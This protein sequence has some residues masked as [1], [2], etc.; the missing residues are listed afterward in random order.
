MNRRETDS[1]V[2]MIQPGFL[3]G[4]SRQD[5]IKLARGG[6]VSHWLARRANTLVL[7][8]DGMSCDAVAK[9]LVLDDDTIRAWYRLYQEDGIEGL[10]GFGYDGSACRLSDAQQEKLIAWITET[11][12]RTTR[13]IGAWIEKGCGIEY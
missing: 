6:S 11:L 8:D 10:A 1:I 2:A 13:E 9:M 12:P 7:L 3:D 5:L 4:E